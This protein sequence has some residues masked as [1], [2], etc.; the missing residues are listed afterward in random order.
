MLDTTFVNIASLI[1]SEPY[2]IVYQM[3]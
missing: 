3:L 1:E 2:E